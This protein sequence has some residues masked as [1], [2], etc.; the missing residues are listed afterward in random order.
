MVS[1]RTV[2]YPDRPTLTEGRRGEVCPDPDC[3]CGGWQVTDAE[4][5][6][7]QGGQ[8]NLPW[9]A[10][11]FHPGDYVVTAHKIACRCGAKG[12]NRER[13]IVNGGLLNEPPLKIY[14]VSEPGIGRIWRKLT[15]AEAS[16]HATRMLAELTA[17][18]ERLPSLPVQDEVAW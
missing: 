9:Y 11:W 16:E 5:S 4:H 6:A 14:L 17:F 1:G 2:T 8:P 12:C 18:D 3:D 7:S 15:A 10:C 13:L